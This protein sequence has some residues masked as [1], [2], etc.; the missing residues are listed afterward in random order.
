MIRLK[1]V[2]KSYGSTR[3][4]ETLSLKIE[5][6]NVHGIV[7]KNGAGKSTLFRSLAGLEKFDSGVVESTWS[8]LKNHLGLLP[9][10]PFV[11]SKV[12]GWEY[13]KLHCLAKHIKEE[14][15]EDKNIFNLPLKRYVEQYSTGMKKKLALMALLLQSNEVLV[16]DEPYNGLDLEG[17][18]LL[19]ELIDRLKSKGIT[20]VISS[21]IF[22]S[23]SEVCDRISLLESGKI[24]MSADKGNFAKLEEALKGSFDNETLKKLG[25]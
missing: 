2:S 16:L 8:P 22:S 11:L 21:H 7:G 1:E 17:S 13:L 9:T 5:K 18:M 10:D 25:L 20:I 4:L 15:F 19:N 24:A 23:L 6:G 12:T 3:V 14:D